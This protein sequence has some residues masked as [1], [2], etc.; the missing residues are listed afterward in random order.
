MPLTI[1]LTRIRSLTTELELFAP[2]GSEPVEAVEFNEKTLVFQLPKSTLTVGSL[3]SL[4][5]TLR[6]PKPAE[7]PITGRVQFC[8]LPGSIFMRVGFELRQFDKELWVR[9]VAAANA[10]QARVD[11]LLAAMK[12]EPRG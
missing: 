2:H 4:T 3:V 7:F 8:E 11:R 6:F 5:C 10:D 12:G 9:F 1:E